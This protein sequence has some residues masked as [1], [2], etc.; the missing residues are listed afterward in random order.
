MSCLRTLPAV[1]LFSAAAFAQG[2][3]ETLGWRL[4][5]GAYSFHRFTFYEAVDKTAALGET[6]IEG[7]FGQ[8][9]GGGITG[10]LDA[11]LTGDQIAA[12]RQKLASAGVKMPSYYVHKI[13]AGESGRG[14]FEFA[15]K[16]GV[17]TIVSEPEPDTLDEVERL[18]N[19][20]GINVAIH[21]HTRD[22][23][24][25]YWDPNNV[26]KAC[27]RRSKRIGV[28]GDTGFWI[29]AG[30]KPAEALRLLK[31]RIMILHVHD[32]D[33][34]GAAGRDV[35]WGEGKAELEEML[36]DVY[37]LEI[38]PVQFTLE[39]SGKFET[40]TAEIAASLAFFNKVLQ[41]IASFQRDYASRT[42]GIRRLAGVS[43][44]ERRKI[45]S[46]LPAKAPA[47]PKKPRNLLIV[48]ANVGRGGHPS[49]PHANMAIEQ[50][51]KK[52]GT[53]Q[54]AVNNDPSVWKPENLKQ[55]DAVFLNN[56]IGDIFGSREARESF[57]AW[58]RDGGGVIANH[59]ATVTAQEWGEFGEILG[60]RGASHRMTDEK[61][62]IKVDL[63]KNPINAA[64]GGKS[65]EFADE[66]FRF[67][68]PYSRA[69]DTVLLSVD[70]ARTDMNQGRCF[71]KCVREDN[72]Y[73]ISW[74]REYGKGRVFYCSL[75]HNP[76]VFW[77]AK[78]LQHFLAGI[79]YALGDLKVRK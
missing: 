75:G 3:R 49:I 69:I 54:A 48:D 17:E 55:F 36:K 72:D 76:Y 9:V 53:W 38:K 40:N 50:M 79:Q 52:L 73:A 41:P 78:I 28:C 25:V 64:F 37:R 62:T 59:A 16:M 63:P 22:I 29:R 14:V 57:A 51:G 71:G 18:A 60:A 58:V 70:V 13:P 35:P 27:E 26:L 74:I 77:D 42:A 10:N 33:E 32:L 6:S 65:F 20:F 4:A 30:F 21:N 1:L 11:S 5:I 45:E 19:E 15:R 66:I 34:L 47:K 23:S 43:A 12:V 46:A 24:P 61:V 7:Y 2:S 67:Q 56:T 8:K 39:Y 44:E 31:D 68:A